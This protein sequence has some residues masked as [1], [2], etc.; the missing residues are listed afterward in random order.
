MACTPFS[1]FLDFG[2][3]LSP[4]FAAGVALDASGA[5]GFAGSSFLPAAGAGAGFF[6]DIML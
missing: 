3:A 5:I 4:G 6:A 2:F 1:F